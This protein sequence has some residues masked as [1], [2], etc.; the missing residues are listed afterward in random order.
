MIFV[1]VHAAVLARRHVQRQTVRPVHHDAIGAD[2]YPAFFRI[3]SNDQ[4]VRAD[5]APAVELVPARHRKFENVDVFAPMNFSK[6]GAGGHGFRGERRNFLH[7]AA[8]SLNELEIAQAAV[9]AEGQRQTS[10]RRNQI[11]CN[12]VALRIIF[13]AVKKNCRTGF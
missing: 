2:V 4:I 13:Y 3:A 7:L 11:R 10:R 1:F 12:P 5:V 6:S 8:P 9:H